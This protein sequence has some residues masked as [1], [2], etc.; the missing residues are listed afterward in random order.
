MY[1]VDTNVFLEIILI[2]DKR[3][4]CKGFLDKNI[5]DIYISDFSLHSVGVILFRYGKVDAFGVFIDDL[6][7]TV[8]YL[9][10][11]IRL[12]RDV[13]RAATE[14]DLDFDD[15]YQYV[16]AKHYKL[17][18]VTMDTDFDVVRDVEVSYL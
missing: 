2:Q 1:L 15:A 4:E 10:L 6:L 17:G 16:L 11:P 7:P 3:E 8:G 14:M 9:S 12:Y 5:R 13:A 18:I